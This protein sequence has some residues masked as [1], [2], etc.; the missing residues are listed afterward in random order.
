MTRAIAAAAALLCAWLTTAASTTLDPHDGLA[1]E[2]RPAVSQDPKCDFSRWHPRRYAAFHLEST[3]SPSLSIDGKLDERAWEDVPWS[4]P[5]QDI[6]GPLHWSQPWFATRVKLLYDDEFLYVAAYLEEDSVWAN[7]TRR[8]DVVFH[9]NDLEVFVDADGTTH[10]YK[11]V[12]VNALNTTW[13]LWLD[14]PY[15]NGGHENSTRVDPAFGFDM[16]GKGMCSAVFVP[17]NVNDPRTLRVNT[18]GATWGLMRLLLPVP[19]TRS[20]TTGQ[21]RWRCR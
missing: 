4:E 1:N 15:R 21:W 13:N 14:R 16:V 10:N 5:F 20:C 17:S 6:R 2:D 7:V 9:D 18:L 19:Q 3:R 12:E 8:N 11:E